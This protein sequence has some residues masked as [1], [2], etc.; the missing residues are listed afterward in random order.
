MPGEWEPHKQTWMG[1][2]IRPDNWREH[3]GP[4]QRAY[5]AVAHAI[6]EFEP[7]TVCVPHVRF[8][9]VRPNCASLYSNGGFEPVIVCITHLRFLHMQLVNFIHWF[10]CE[11]SMSSNP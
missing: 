1:W 4:A 5:A 8:L 3:A 7:V 2:P 9:D 10:D 6:N 11:P